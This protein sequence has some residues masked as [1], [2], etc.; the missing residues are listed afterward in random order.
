MSTTGAEMIIV[1]I[2]V[3]TGGMRGTE[4]TWAVRPPRDEVEVSTPEGW[5][6]AQFTQPFKIEGS[7][8]VLVFNRDDT[9]AL[10]R[11]LDR[12]DEVFD[13]EALETGE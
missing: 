9:D 13:S 12:I 4:Y 11:L 8:D 7:S 5:S 3:S 10:R 6:A 2:P 1:D